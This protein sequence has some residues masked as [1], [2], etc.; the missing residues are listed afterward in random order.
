MCFDSLHRRSGGHGGCP[1]VVIVGG[2]I[3][4]LLTALYLA[5]LP[6]IL[7]T[8]APLGEGSA[9]SW[10]QG[11]LAAAV[12]PDDD[13]ALHAADTLSAADGLA[14]PAVAARVAAAA[15]HAVADL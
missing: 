5:P 6:C 15:P 4:G 8:K 1:P 9:T 10:A 12:G 14:D 11:G 13:P 2:G 7:L 3:A